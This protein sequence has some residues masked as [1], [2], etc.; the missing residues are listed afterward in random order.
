MTTKSS[1][2]L[3]ELDESELSNFD[4]TAKELYLTLDKTT[5]LTDE[6]IFEKF[7]EYN[8]N[9]EVLQQAKK[10]AMEFFGMMN[11]EW[12]YIYTPDGWK[13]FKIHD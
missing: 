13:T 6:E 10:K 8:N 12:F 7:P 2:T 1:N 4:F 11:C 9:P 5:E 3:L